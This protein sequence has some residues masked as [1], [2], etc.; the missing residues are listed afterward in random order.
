[1]TSHIIFSLNICLHKNANKHYNLHNSF[2]PANE[3]LGE[4]VWAIIHN[5]FSP[6]SAISYANQNIV[7]ILSL[8]NSPHCY[9][10]EEFFVEALGSLKNDQEMKKWIADILPKMHPRDFCPVILSDLTFD[11]FSEF[12]ASKTLLR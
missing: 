2:S 5:V 8:F 10:Q 3:P 6:K 4:K 7:F 9:F 11:F 1:M 12:L